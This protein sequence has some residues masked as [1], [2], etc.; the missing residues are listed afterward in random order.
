MSMITNDILSYWFGIHVMVKQVN[1]NDNFLPSKYY[2]V[3]VIVSFKNSIGCM[4]FYIVL[5]TCRVPLGERWALAGK[6]M[7]L[8]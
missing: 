4:C 1:V 8:I 7:E 3:K 6:A 2:A 5:F